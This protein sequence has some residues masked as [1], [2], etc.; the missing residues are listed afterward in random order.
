MSNAVICGW[1]KDNRSSRERRYILP[2]GLPES[3]TC[4]QSRLSSGATRGH[5]GGRHLRPRLALAE[6]GPFAKACPRLPAQPVRLPRKLAFLE[7]ENSARPAFRPPAKGT[8]TKSGAYEIGRG[9]GKIGS[10]T[11]RRSKP[12]TTKP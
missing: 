6:Q 4:R 10:L 7:R 8:H 2:V 5:S 9:T 1:R 3:Q 11:F 12:A